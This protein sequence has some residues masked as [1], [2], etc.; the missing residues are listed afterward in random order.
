MPEVAYINGTFCPINEATVSIEDRGFQFGD[1]IYEV[2][3]A[4]GRKL[5]E[6][7]AHLKRLRAS[8]KAIDLAFD[9]EASGLT[10]AMREG[11]TRCE[12]EDVMVYLQ[13]TRGVAPRVHTIPDGLVPTVVMTFK[14]IPTISS[15]LQKRGA[16]LKTFP[17]VRWANCYIK[18]TTL[19]PNILAKT[20]AKKA[21]YDDAVFVTEEGEVRESTSANVYIV[22]GKSVIFPRRNESVLHGVTQHFLMRCA[23]ALGLEMQ[24]GVI[25]LERLMAADEVFISSTAVEVLGVTCVDGKAIATGE[26]GPVVRSLHEEFCRRARSP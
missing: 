14:E 23:Q 6:L 9:I 3:F 10:Q 25:P 8:L 22:E 19:L 18:A 17:E 5:F 16:R 11:V 20:R 12:F 26:V 13:I 1:S 15:E 24:E 7:D 21:G 2:I 4:Y